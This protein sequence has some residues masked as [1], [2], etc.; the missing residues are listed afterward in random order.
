MARILVVEDDNQLQQNIAELL[1]L[2]D[3]EVQVAWNGEQGLDVLRSFLP[4]LILCDI[5]MPQMDGIAFIRA[6]KNDAQLRSIPFIFLTAKVSQQDLIQGLEEGAVDYLAKPFMH[7][8]LLLKINNITSQQRELVVHQLQHSIARQDSDFQF[9]KQFTEVLEQHFEDSTL[10]ADQMAE[11]MNMSLSALQRNLK[12]YLQKSF[13]EM[14]RDYRLRKATNYLT[15][16]DYSVQWIA[17]HCGFSRLSYF[18]YC[19]KE[20]YQVSPLQFRAGM[21]SGPEL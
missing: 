6:V 19:F 11:M 12:K 8:E 7:K 9:V 20:T 18:S 15:Q 5:M 4:H 21:R 1:K 14:L 16:T 10:S 17:S 3:H 13:T 2:N